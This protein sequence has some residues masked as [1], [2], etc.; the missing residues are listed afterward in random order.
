MKIHGLAALLVLVA[1]TAFA[2]RDALIDHTD[3]W[4][5]F[6]KFEVSITE[7]DESSSAL[8]GLSVG[9]LLNDRL[10][11]G[12]AG[13]ALIDNAS[14]RS[15]NL[16]SIGALDFWYGGAYL[17]YVFGSENL[18]YATVDALIGGG[19]L[20]VDDVFGNSYANNLFVAEPGINLMVNITETFMFGLGVSYRFVEGSDLAD[21][22]DQ[23]LSGWTGN[24][25]FR[26][27]Q[28]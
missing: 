13:H 22:R 12:L 26:F 21:I 15:S 25:F 27:T 1:G 18:V 20:E 11:L 14:T 16:R 8:A 2:Q 19:R 9:G 24:A 6:S 28:F 10:G 4:N 3:K 17:E 7:I 23:D 5:L